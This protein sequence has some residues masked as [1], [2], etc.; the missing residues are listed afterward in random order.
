MAALALKT[1]GNEALEK[2]QYAKAC[3]IYTQA[4]EIDGSNHV[5]LRRVSQ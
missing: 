1:Q 5:R 2:S 3:F 4:I